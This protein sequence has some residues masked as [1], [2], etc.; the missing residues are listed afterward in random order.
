M[1]PCDHPE[2]INTHA[3]PSMAM[4]AAEEAGEKKTSAHPISETTRKL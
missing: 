4:R 1:A 2:S 3:E